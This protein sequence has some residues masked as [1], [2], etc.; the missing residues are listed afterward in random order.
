MEKIIK[1]GCEISALTLGTVQLGIPYGINNTH[2]MPTFDESS[3]LLT[4]AINL[5]VTAFDT[6]R[7]YGKSEEVLGRYFTENPPHKTI[8]TKVEFSEETLDNVVD[9]FF[10]QIEDSKKKLGVD[11]LSGVLLHS[12]RHIENYGKTLIDA[13]VESKKRGDVK[14]IGVSLS[15]KEKMM[16]YLSDGVFDCVQIPA[17]VF[18][19]K[20]IR[21]GKVKA[22]SD[23]GISVFV[24]SVYLQGLFFRSLDTLPE[25]LV[26]AKPMIEELH[27]LATDNGISVA[28][29]ALSYIRD[30]EGVASLVMGAETPE[31]VRENVALFDTPKLSKSVMDKITEISESVPPIVIRPWEWNK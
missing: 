2:G 4:T 18:D 27:K 5:G 17:N 1:N 31:Q 22:L 8:I 10:Y 23:M 25:K 20:E 13:L 7:G 15:R 9:S 6:A 30:T 26:C 24:R 12:E 19:N 3:E 29:L 14:N 16:E 11:S 21:E 28:T